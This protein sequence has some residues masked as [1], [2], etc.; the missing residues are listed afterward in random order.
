MYS[1]QET[2]FDFLNILKINMIGGYASLDKSVIP[3]VMNFVTKLIGIPYKW[4][5]S[6]ELPGDN[7]FWASNEKVPSIEYIRGKDKSTVCA[8]LINLMRRHLGLGIPGLIHDKSATLRKYYEE[9]PLY[10]PFAG[11]TSNWWHYLELNGRLENLDRT[12]KYPIG[13]LL[14]SQ[15]IEV[16]GD[17]GHVAVVYDNP[18]SGATGN[19]RNQNIIHATTDDSFHATS[20]NDIAGDTRVEPF[21][22]LDNVIIGDKK[23]GY[24]QKVCLPE[25]WLLIN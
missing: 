13:T 1:I 8:G 22:I 25:N 18:V 2:L 14:L 10:R 20:G 4:Y 7:Q 19:I 16:E 3:D 5:R 12:K 17:Q 9:N 23:E 6:G 11:D 24:F 15:F 21:T